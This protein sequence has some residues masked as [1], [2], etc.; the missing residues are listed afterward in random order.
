MLLT[1][2]SIK[3][4]SHPLKSGVIYK[5]IQS[6]GKEESAFPAESA[7]DKGLF[8]SDS[9]I[10]NPRYSLWQP[11]LFVIILLLTFHIS[12]PQLS[13]CKERLIS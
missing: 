6:S 2:P 13:T 8:L 5:L 12:L 1:R 9:F 7:W 4:S 11:F 3:F 10:N